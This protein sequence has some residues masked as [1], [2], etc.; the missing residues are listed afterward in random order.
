[1]KEIFFV[2]GFQAAGVAAGLKK[3]GKKDLGLIFSTVP[4]AVAGVFTRNRIQ[5]APVVLDRQ[6]LQTGKGRA[7]VVNSGN[8]NCCT[9]EQGMQ[10]ALAMAKAVADGLDLPEEQVL[11]ASTGVIGEQL[12]IQKIK[13]AVPALLG[14]L[15]PEG[16]SELAEAIMTTDTVPKVVAVKKQLAGKSFHLAAVAKGAGMIRPD[17]ATMLCFVIS[18]I[19]PPAAVMQ[20]MLKTAVD[21]SFNRITVDGDMSTNDTVIFMANGASGVAA[22]TREARRV[23]QGVLDDALLQL[24]RL[25]VKDGEGATKLVDVRVRGAASDPD[26]RSVADTVANSSLV[27]TA[28]FGQDANWGRILAAAGRAGVP[29]DPARVDIYFDKVMMVK[30]GLGRGK[31]VEAQAT[32]VLKKPEFVITIDLKM[33]SGRASVL[34]CDFSIDYVKINADYRS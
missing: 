31:A 26:A 24:A 7:I 5:A 21:R 8:A 1:M 13:T 6:R 29:I 32:A 15:K 20:T 30:D 11:V 2:N 27:K 25:C 34:T 16:L 23:L 17:M 12:P 22:E 10:N 33:A 19:E 4:A 18:D 9:G 28:L 14:A 3:N